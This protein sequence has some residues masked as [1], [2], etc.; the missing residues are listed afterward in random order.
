MSIPTTPKQQ[1]NLIKQ[2]FNSDEKKGR[3]TRLI[4]QALTIDEFKQRFERRQ[5]LLKL[6]NGRTILDLNELDKLLQAYIDFEK[7]KNRQGGIKTFDEFLLQ[8]QTQYFIFGS[9]YKSPDN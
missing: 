2:L 6:Q 5:F 1:T 3:L 9:T 7:Q 4:N 8:M